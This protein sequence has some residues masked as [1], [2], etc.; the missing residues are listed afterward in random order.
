M[1]LKVVALIYT[2]V[3][4][5]RMRTGK[6]EG[7]SESFGQNALYFK[8]VVLVTKKGKREQNN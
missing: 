4:E 1:Y 3:T 7:K 2:L 5:R 6:K 8:V